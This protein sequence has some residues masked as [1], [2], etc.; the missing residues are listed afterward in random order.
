MLAAPSANPVIAMPVTGAAGVA[1]V[2]SGLN[3]TLP[4]LKLPWARR[5]RR[6]RRR[7]E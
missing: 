2:P 6:Y 5:F 7:A 4:A 3:V 1:S